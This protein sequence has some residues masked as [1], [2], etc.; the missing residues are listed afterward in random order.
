MGTGQALTAVVTSFLDQKGWSYVELG[1][2]ALALRYDGRHASFRCRVRIDEQR[3]QVAFHSL[4]PAVVPPEARLAVVDYITRANARLV[5][6]NFDVDID[7][8]ELRFRTSIDVEGDR[9]TPALL[10][11]V[12]HANVVTMDRH[13]PELG[14]VIQACVASVPQDPTR[15]AAPPGA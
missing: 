9:L 10:T 14:A 13:L 3:G 8:G 12:V 6:G 4:F 5:I 11:H 1:D 2:G 7:R 15:P